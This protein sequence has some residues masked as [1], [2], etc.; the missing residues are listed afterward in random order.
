MMTE[1]NALTRISAYVAENRIKATL[2]ADF[3]QKMTVEANQ[4]EDNIKIKVG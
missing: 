3:Q 4:I 1:S 2:E